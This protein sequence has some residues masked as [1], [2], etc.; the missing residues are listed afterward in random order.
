MQDPLGNGMIIKCRKG[1]TY[2]SGEYVKSLGRLPIIGDQRKNGD[3]QIRFIDELDP[4]RQ[5]CL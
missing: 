2:V 3:A 1:I 4:L 5:L